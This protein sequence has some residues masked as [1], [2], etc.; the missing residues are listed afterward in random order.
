MSNT[1]TSSVVNC[2]ARAYDFLV[3]LT[4]SRPEALTWDSTHRL[5]GHIQLCG[6]ELNRYRPRLGRRDGDG[7]ARTSRGSSALRRRP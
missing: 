6:H 3:R 2:Q 4:G 5:Q 7:R 1:N